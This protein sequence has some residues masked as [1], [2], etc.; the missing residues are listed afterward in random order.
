[1]PTENELAVLRAARL[2]GIT[3]R[4]ELANLMAQ[5]G[6]ESGGFARLEESFR[7][8]R[9]IDAIPVSSAFREGRAVLEAARVE[10]LAGRPQKLA[11]LMYGGRMGND[12]AG[13][14]YRYRGRG[15][16]MLTGESNYREA[17]IAL[18]LDLVAHPELA[19][20]RDNAARIALWYWRERVPAARREDVS[21]A[22]VAINGGQNGLADRHDRFDAWQAVLTPQFLADLDA[23][24]VRPGRGVGPAS[25]REVAADG[26]LRRLE[27][28][29]AV[30][31][32]QRDL[33]GLGL[34]DDRGRLPRES[35]VFDAAT[36]QAVRR[37]QHA[38]DEPVT[39]R[40]DADMQRALDEADVPTQH[41]PAPRGATPPHG[42]RAT[43]RDRLSVSD[44]RLLDSLVATVGELDR[45]CGRTFDAASERM[46]WSLLAAAK[47][48]GITQV[49]HVVLNVATP[50]LRAGE[51]VFVVQGA[52]DDPA[53]RVA[54]LK[55]HE[56]VDTPIE[57]S[58]EQLHA[59]DAA[60]PAQRCAQ[61]PEQV[62]CQAHRTVMS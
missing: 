24:R 49:D 51:N 31:E 33:R 18:G 22:T 58:I 4:D 39:G 28:G 5:L 44:A 34:R 38:H 52:L 59:M 3:S 41:P 61:A 10:A 42:A 57:R 17:G 32:L 50:Q 23:D 47:A 60:L 7:Y 56:A 48:Q 35:G 1:M 55:T 6:H 40:V 8:T 19:A 54:C 26:E 46:A 9:G 30:T 25:A 20:D 62:A 45:S 43:D 27:R 36:E 21:A 13:D 37:F 2:A 15:F 53:H 16:T 14:G 12:D 11:R 29:D